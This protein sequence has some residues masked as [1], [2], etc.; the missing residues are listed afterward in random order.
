MDVPSAA[1]QIL[2]GAFYALRRPPTSYLLLTVDVTLMQNLRES[3][4]ELLALISSAGLTPHFNGQRWNAAQWAQLVSLLRV[5]GESVLHCIKSKS[6]LRI[7][8]LLG[9]YH[10]S[11]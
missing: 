8:E 6:E 7:D 4:M 9:G 3:P 10:V 5:R 11:E 1:L 2:R